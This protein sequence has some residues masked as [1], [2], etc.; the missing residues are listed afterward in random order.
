MSKC[1]FNSCDKPVN[2]RGKFCAAHDAQEQSAAEAVKAIF[3]SVEGEV[4]SMPLDISKEVCAC[5][6]NKAEMTILNKNIAHTDL[7][8][9]CFAAWKKK[10]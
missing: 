7:C 3:D 6:K 4:L 8:A 2:A 9:R 10:G 1:F 5:C